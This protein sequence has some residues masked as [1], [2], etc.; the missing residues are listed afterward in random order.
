M[1]RPNRLALGVI[2]AAACCAAPRHAAAGTDGG[3]APNSPFQLEPLKDPSTVFLSAGPATAPVESS[4]VATEGLLMQGL[5]Q[6]GVGQWM[7]QNRIKAFGWIEGS[8]N[9]NFQ[10]PEPRLN[11]GHLFDIQDSNAVINQLEVNVERT[12]NLS[13]QQFDVGGRIDLL[14]GTD[15]RFIH[16][17][18]LL[19]GSFP[20]PQYQFDIPQLY[21]DIAVPL[22]DGLRVRLGKFEFFKLT[23]PNASPFFSHT[24][25]YSTS[26]Q[27][28]SASRLLS[29]GAGAALP[30]TLTGITGYY[31]FNKQVNLE[32]GL[33]RGYDQSLTDNNGAIDAFGR[34]NYKLS[35]ETRASFALITGPEINHDNSH[36]RTV[37]DV[38]VAQSISENLLILADGFYGVQARPTT[39]DGIA[40]GN[41]A[42]W[43][44][45]NGTAVYEISRNLS[46][47]GR[48][49]WYRDEQGFTTGFGRGVTLYEA[50]AGVTITPFPDSDAGRGLKIRPEIRYDFADKHFF[51]NTSP[52][53]Y[54]WIAS[55][56]AV[57]NF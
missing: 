33:G 44:G 1:K 41:D 39:L 48:L 54:Q 22:V 8:Y 43:Y 6:V 38:S 46:L 2:L 50:T 55:V 31:E 28:N 53:G 4:N 19:A 45:L 51:A 56:D 26:G 3:A 49:E 11:F 36:Y 34:L 5:D 37:G 7:T 42:H 29:T 15:A 13:S 12:V 18:G 52:G 57:Y 16:S 24:Y 9:Y 32:A 27:S 10:N 30:F 25:L 21:V 23:D 40:I 20:N 47:A 14:Y 35:Q 17:S